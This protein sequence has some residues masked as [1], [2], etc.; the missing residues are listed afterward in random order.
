NAPISQTSGRK[1]TGVNRLWSLWPLLLPLLLFIPGLI[2]FPY[3]SSAAAYSDVTISHYP[4]AIFL[5]RAVSEWGLVPLW[6]PTILSGYPFAAN[7]LS[8]LW[9]PPGWLALLFPLPLGFNLL[10]MLHLLW[11][12]VGMYRLLRTEKIS[13]RAAL[14]GALAF[15]SLPK[16]FAH[17]GAGHLSLLYAVPW[18]PWLLLG[19]GVRC[20]VSGVRYQ[21]SG[22][23]KQGVLR[24][25]LQP[26][27]ILALIFLA[28]PRWVPFATLLWIAYVYAYRHYD[29]QKKQKESYRHS[30]FA[31]H[32]SP[33][34]IHHSPFTIHHSSFII[35]HSSFIIH[36][37]IVALLLAVPLLLPLLEYVRIST[38][39]GLASADVFLH[40]LPPARLMGLLCP[41]FG[42]YHEWMLYPGGVALVLVVVALLASKKR[43]RVYF[44]VG[45]FAL[46]LLYSLGSHLPLLPKLAQLPG[47]NLMRVPA[48][49]LFLAG[50]AGA[51]LAAYGLDVLPSTNR[52]DSASTR[53]RLVLTALTAFA[54]LLAV[55]ARVLTG[56]WTLN[57][58]WGAGAIL[59]A[60]LGVVTRIRERLP[61]SIWYIII[62]GLAIFDWGAVNASV[63]SFHARDV[64]ISEKESVAQY[65]SAQPGMFRVY[66]PSY[67]LPQHTAAR[68]G[69]EL[70]DGVDPLQLAAYAGFMDAATGVPRDGYGVTLP[71]FADGQ[72]QRD[73]AA[74][75]PDAALLG[76]LNVRYVVSEYDLAVDGLLLRKQF[77]E[78]RVYENLLDV[79]RIVNPT[80]VK[81]IGN[82]LAYPTLAQNANIIDWTPNKITVE[83][84][85][86]GL[87]VLSEMAYPGWRV[88][89]DGEAA[90]LETVEGILRGVRLPPGEHRVVFVYRSLSVYLGL[91][92]FIFGIVLLVCDG[93]RRKGRETE[94]G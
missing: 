48:R 65:L 61:A 74:Y 31:I 69:L 40:S 55:A 32:H 63:L 57:L 6:S 72:P 73:N 1:S 71:P 11:G 68:Y 52:S 70:A 79:G 59:L 35:H 58:V 30:P 5:K 42:G 92:G 75:R 81:R 49:A 89:V 94:R 41:D 60:S 25:G 93:R 85:G 56:A 37:S 38:R 50:M 43:G 53:V 62:F 2:D 39:S 44:W 33:F 77:G 66:S 83:A 19:K 20:Q 3:P 22:N 86:P 23:R 28:D 13:H 17:Y 76:L 51:V 88:R 24:I 80:P 46:S 12:G 16:L 29:G 82:P 47:L 78:T 54:V 84:D 18:T 45:A 90:E 21:V 64:V 10:V 67:S 27:V 14:F 34:I 9:Y 36:H 87:L 15:E 91:L 7:P 26:G 4:N 8:G